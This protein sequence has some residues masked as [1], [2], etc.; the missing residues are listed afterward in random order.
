MALEGAIVRAPSNEAAHDGQSGVAQMLCAS[1]RPHDE[2]L[3]KYVPLQCG[4][5]ERSHSL[6]ILARAQR[7]SAA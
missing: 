5:G 7:G 6:V 2:P 1:E 4:L 3:T